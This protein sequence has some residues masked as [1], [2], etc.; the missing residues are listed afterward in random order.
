MDQLVFEFHSCQ[1]YVELRV[2][3]HVAS[4]VLRQRRNRGKVHVGLWSDEHLDRD[5]RLRELGGQSL[6][7]FP[8]RPQQLDLAVLAQDVRIVARGLQGQLADAWDART[9]HQELASDVLHR[10]ARALH[11]GAHA[12]LVDFRVAVD[13]RDRIQKTQD[14]RLVFSK[15]HEDVVGKWEED[16]LEVGY[17]ENLRLA[18]AAVQVVEMQRRIVRDDPH[19]RPLA[20]GDATRLDGLLYPRH[21][22][23]KHTGH[24]GGEGD[25]DHEHEDWCLGWPHHVLAWSDI[26]HSALAKLVAREAVGP[27]ASLVQGGIVRVRRGLHRATEVAQPTAAV[28]LPLHERVDV[29]STFPAPDDCANGAEADGRYRLLVRRRGRKR[30]QN[31]AKRE[32]NLLLAAG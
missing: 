18:Q 30:L 16:V 10:Q 19:L 2:V 21:D 14:H 22:C 15:V 29:S 7:A 5:L 8:H 32:P 1:L 28:R 31:D 9:E 11:S 25:I 17:D 13:V 6:V 26:F 24:H 3:T 4:G 12:R 20:P 27:L 23:V